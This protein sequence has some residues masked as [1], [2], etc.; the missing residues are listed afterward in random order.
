DNCYVQETPHHS[1][2]RN[3]V[4]WFLLRTFLI[5]VAVMLHYFV[6]KLCRVQ[7]FGRWSSKL[8]IARQ[9]LV[10]LPGRLSMGIPFLAHTSLY[11]EAR[12]SRFM[13]GGWFLCL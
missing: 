11:Q 8:S 2:L 9:D 10:P 4:A 6:H 1:V 7:D 12:M 13:I 5:A 3:R